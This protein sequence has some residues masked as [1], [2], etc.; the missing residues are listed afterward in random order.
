[1]DSIKLL[2]R[3][4]IMALGVLAYRY[5][6]YSYFAKVAENK[7]AQ[8]R[9]DAEANPMRR[10]LSDKYMTAMEESGVAVGRMIDTQVALSRMVSRM[11]LSVSL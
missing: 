6:S 4:D 3:A 5:D 1:M 11:S 2:D 10:D 7:E 9:A 8:A